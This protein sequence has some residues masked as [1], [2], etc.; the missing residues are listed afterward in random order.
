VHV[1]SH[2]THQNAYFYLFDDDGEVLYPMLTKRLD[3][4]KGDRTSGLLFVSER[5]EPGKAR[6]W[7]VSELREV[8]AEICKE[9]GLPHLTLSQFRKGGLSEAGAAGL[10]TSQIM[11]Q[12]L[13]LTEEAVQMY[14]DKNAEVAMGGQQLR[15]KY[16]GKLQKRGVDIVT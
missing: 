14:I 9:A 2:K 12:S 7:T 3:E 16:R 1:K 15:L 4:L 6:A 8:V 13:H 5:S 11:S 10:S